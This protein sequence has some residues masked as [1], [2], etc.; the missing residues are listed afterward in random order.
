MPPAVKVVGVGPGRRAYASELALKV[1]SEARVL[2][3]GHRLLREFASSHQEQHS[4]DGRLERALEIIRRESDRGGV[5]VLVSGDTG[6]FSFAAYLKRHLDAGELEF[7]P[8]ISSFQLLFARIQRPWQEAA[9]ISVHGRPPAYLPQAVREEKAVVLFTGKTWTPPALARYLLEEG[10][11]EM[12]V[13]IGKDLSYSRE[14]VIWS[15]L[16]DLAV[17][18]RDWQNSVMVIFNE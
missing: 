4:L 15:S 11:P 3:G 9:F 6:M 8:G 5:V 18:S 16:A 12:W 17:S 14:E 13:A 1:I 10:V 2:V 7:I